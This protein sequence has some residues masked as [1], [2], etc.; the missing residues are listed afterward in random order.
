MGAMELSALWAEAGGCVAVIGVSVEN[1]VTQ[2]AA[3][4]AGSRESPAQCLKKL[5]RGRWNLKM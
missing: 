5:V 1:G 4:W 3:Q 2:E